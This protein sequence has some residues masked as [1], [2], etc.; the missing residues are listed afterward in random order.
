MI[1]VI[2]KNVALLTYV[3]NLKEYCR[4]YNKYREDYNIYREY[5]WRSDRRG[6]RRVCRHRSAMM[7]VTKNMKKMKSVLLNFLVAY[8]SM[9]T[10]TSRFTSLFSDPSSSLFGCLDSCMF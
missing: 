2:A 8:Y 6:T 7:T 9:A 3:N 1:D 5:A 4:G 10:Y